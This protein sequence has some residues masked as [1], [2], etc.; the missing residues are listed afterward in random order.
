MARNSQKTAK[1]ITTEPYL[2]V[3]ASIAEINALA[4]ECNAP[5][6]A[7]V[8]ITEDYGSWVSFKWVLEQEVDL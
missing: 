3:V 5:P 6:R 8:T 2:V 7:Q 4:E 1:Y